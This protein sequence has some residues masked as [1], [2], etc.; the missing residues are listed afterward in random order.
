MAKLSSPQT[1]AG[2]GYSDVA[3]ADH[4]SRGSANIVVPLLQRLLR[5]A[6]VV[7]VGCGVGIWLRRFQAEGVTDICG[8]DGTWVD[9]RLLQIDRSQFHPCDFEA[10]IGAERRYSLALC[11]E[12]AE[13]LT[14]AAGDRLVRSLCELSSLVVFSAAIPGQGGFRHINE[15]YQSYWIE[16]FARHSYK[17]FDLLRARLF[18]ESAVR[19]YYSQNMLIFAGEEKVEAMM[20]LSIEQLRA[21]HIVPPSLVHPELFERYRV[22]EN[23]GPRRLA[24]ALLRATWRRLFSTT[25]APAGPFLHAAR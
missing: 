10:G 25:K 5:P 18:R 22:T 4:E 2:Y 13:H 14:P 6:S 24:T 20:E 1:A 15:R 17:P 8:Y 9:A 12:V 21:G 19:Y 3:L 11:L 23:H 7:D 16:R